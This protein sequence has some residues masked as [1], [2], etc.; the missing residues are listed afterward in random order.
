[1]N[2]L[3][4]EKKN[5]IKKETIKEFNVWNLNKKLSTDKILPIINNDMKSIK[6]LVNIL[7]EENEQNKEK[8]YYNYKSKVLKRTNSTESYNIRSSKTKT[9]LN[10]I[11]QNLHN[12]QD[13]TNKIINLN[14]LYMNH[15]SRDSNIFKFQY[16]DNENK[17][18]KNI[19]NYSFFSKKNFDK[20]IKNFE[21][22]TNNNRKQLKNAFMKFNPY[23]HL[24]N[25]HML[26]KS[27]PFIQNDISTLKKEIDEDI[28]D[29]TDIHKLKK[30]YE[31]I[32]NNNYKS[33]SSENIL[34]KDDSSSQYKKVKY[35]KKH[36]DFFQK[37]KKTPKIK[38]IY[39]EDK[40]EEINKILN[41]TGS[42]KNFIDNDYINTNIE[43]Y[44]NDYSKN[45][46]NNENKFIVNTNE[47]FSERNKEIIDDFK[48]LYSFRLNR[49]VEEN[50]K[51]NLNRAN[52]ENENFSNK[53][54]G[55]KNSFLNELN[56][57]LQK[58]EINLNPVSL[59]EKDNIK[60]MN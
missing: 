32:Q 50:E 59:K 9:L 47:Y 5:E 13:S 46:Y 30:K 35:I 20:K 52:R 53:V 37:D 51:R 6:Q 40:I 21:Y 23:F 31:K 28:K 17:N 14:D 18:E 3:S 4:N 55:I 10:K 7:I 56:S 26:E 11:E 22:I 12:I 15:T 34:K 43:K 58:N 39:R 29:V 25:L 27:F 19:T 44:V 2:K 42:I 48:E 38:S 33:K 45:K 8:K 49:V 60:E 36:L 54:L 24:E 41:C 57:Y 1:M 16:S